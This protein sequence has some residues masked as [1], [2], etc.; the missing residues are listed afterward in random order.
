MENNIHTL[1]ERIK[2]SDLSESDKKVLI[3]KLDRATPDIPGFVSSL[4]MVLKI[5]N[6][7]LKLFDI[8]FWDDF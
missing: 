1:I 6:E 2:E 4:I 7:V 8:N 5:S 3:E